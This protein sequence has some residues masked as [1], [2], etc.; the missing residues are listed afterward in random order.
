MGCMEGRIA[1]VTGASTGIGRAAAPAFAA[2]GAAVALAD[3]DATR[4]EELAAA[5]RDKGDASTPRSTTPGSRV[6]RRGSTSAA[7]VRGTA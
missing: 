5:L 3:L 4:G 7:P 6:S 2:E 1:L